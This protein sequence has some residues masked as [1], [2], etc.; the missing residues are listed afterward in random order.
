[1]AI[2]NREISRILSEMADLLDIKGENQFRVRAYRNA[3]RSVEDLPKPAGELIAEDTDLSSFPGIGSAIAE[4]IKQ[5]VETGTI[6]QLEQLKKEL[7][8]GLLDMLKIP[9]LG[10]RRVGDLYRH[11]GVSDLDDLAHAA[12]HSTID[13]VP[14]FGKK[15]SESIRKNVQTLRTT[16]KENRVLLSEAEEIA[17]ELL[18][19]LQSGSDRAVAIEHL[20]LAGSYRRRKETVGDLDILVIAGGNKGGAAT[21]DQA[22]AIMDRF[23]GYDG[24]DEVITHG[25]TRSSVILRGGTQVDLRLVDRESYG[26]A[27]M[28]F[29]G[30]KEHNVAVRRIAQEK[31]YKVSEYGVF[32]SGETGGDP[33]DDD[34]DNDSGRR[35]AGATE[36]EVFGVLGLDWVPPELRENRGEV[37]AAREGRLPVLIELSNIRG[38]LHAHT[39]WSDGMFSLEEMA[40]AAMDRGYE[41]LAVTDHSKGL[42]VANGLD[43]QR[44]AQQIDAI[45]ELNESFE[46]FQLLSSMEVNIN[47]DGSL[48]LSQ[49][50]L[51]RLDMVICS[52]HSGLDQPRE[53][54]T[55]RMLRAMDNPNCSIIGHPTGR[56]LNKRGGY[57][58][59]FDRIFEAARRH[60]VAMEINAQPERLDLRD[61]HARRAAEAGIALTI[62]TDAHSTRNLDLMHYG[63]E[64][65]RRAWI[66]PEQV[67]NTRSLPELR[68]MLRHG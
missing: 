58:L 4:K 11:L 26:A 14:G 25:E 30:S 35:V 60:G 57:D 2:H 28:Y 18:D 8:P 10:P 24:V 63:I 34:N 67:L 31:G 3:A 59:D 54:Q 6:T 29:T 46:G 5:L 62:S 13:Q 38:D 41:Y 48:D 37:Q 64:Q 39:N 20:Q 49:E 21:L 53:K 12:Y 40:R 36:E 45:A 43:E 17:E 50:L 61:S 47:A 27:L 33:D 56:Q 44:L 16:S 19:H 68:Q 9:E 51:A 42:T 65:A 52:I 22:A 55:E 23:V 15:L 7:P 1:M 32:R 66:T